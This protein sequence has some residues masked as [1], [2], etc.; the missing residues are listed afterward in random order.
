MGRSSSD[1]FRLKVRLKQTLSSFFLIDK[2]LNKHY[3]SKFFIAEEAEDDWYLEAVLVIKVTYTSGNSDLIDK[4]KPL[5][6]Q[7]N[8]QHLACSPYFKDYYRSLTFKDRKQAILQ[9]AFGGEVHVD[10]ALNKE[11]E[12]VGY[13]VSSVDRL[14]T[15]EVDSLFV[16]PIC[17]GQGIGTTFMEKTLEWFK[18][19]G[20]KKNIV[21]VAVGNEQAYVFYQ[22]FGFYPRRTL[23][24]QKKR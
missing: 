10:L 14:L 20:T 12:V 3:F 9:R 18:T 21:S 15:G 11:E 2:N 5:W 17:R 8:K 13:C 19:K 4:V 1:K 24:E 6:E 16:V 22:Q 7:L 23:L